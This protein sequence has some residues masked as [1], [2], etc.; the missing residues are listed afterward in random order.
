MIRTVCGSVDPPRR[1]AWRAVA[2]CKFA[3][4]RHTAVVA[5]D[6][7]NAMIT[8]TYCTCR[9]PLRLHTSSLT[10]TRKN[11]AERSLAIGGGTLFYPTETLGNEAR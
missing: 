4:Q 7:E 3:Q 2:F 9:T 1:E 10:K 8:R 5:A 11:K 6:R